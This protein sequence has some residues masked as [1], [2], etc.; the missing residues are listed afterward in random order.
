M[1]LL[2]G[3]IEQLNTFDLFIFGGTGD[4]ANRKLLP[5]LYKQSSI[6]S[7]SSESRIIVIGT[8][9]L[10]TEEYLQTLNKSLQEYS[11]DYSNTKAE[12]FFSKISYLK[13]D[14]NNGEDWKNFSAQKYNTTRIFYLAIPPALYQITTSKLKTHNCITDDSKIVVEKPIGSCL[15]TAKKINNVL[16]EGFAEKQIYRIDHYLGKE[17]VQNLLALRFG[18][19]IFEQSWSNRAIDHIQ[20]S[21]AEDLGVEDRGSYYDKTGALRDMVQNHLIQILCLIAMEPPVSI[22]SESVR[23]EKLKVLRSLAP[24]DKENIKHNSVRGRYVDGVHKKEPVRGYLAE[25]GVNES[26]NTET[27]VALKLLINNWRWSGVPFYIRTGKRM[28][29][30]VSEIVVRYKNIPHNIF[31]SDATLQPNQ[32]VLRIHPDEGVDLK[33]NTKEPSVSGF[34][35]EELP[36]DLNLQDYYEL[37]HQDCYERLLL[38]IIKGNQALF[39]RK[40]EIEASWKWIDAIVKLW[41]SEDVPMEEYISGTWGPSSSEIMLSKENRKWA[42]KN[43]S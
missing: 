1:G 29:K 28:M 41:E 24:F 8:R 20:I 15:E 36:L 10:T 9:N 2:M 22:N 7:F 26:N 40:D 17:A 23:D 12:K 37:G 35:L 13:I 27:F 38:D 25:K 6:K 43:Q 4:L 18:N 30:K 34:N 11:A 33:L 14:V 39:V 32:L 16:A 42:N 21:V 19:I 31:S 3:E 5:A